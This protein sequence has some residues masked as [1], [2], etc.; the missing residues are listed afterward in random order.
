MEE[1]E[2]DVELTV[3]DLYGFSMRHTY[4]GISG[5]FGLIISL[6][7]LVICGIQFKQLDTTARIALLIIGCLFTVV[8]P[9]MLYTKAKTQ[10]KQN[11]NINS[12]L[13]Y[14]LAEEGIEVSQG[15]QTVFVK[16]FDVRRKVE[17]GKAIYLYMSPVRA[18]IFPANQCGMRFKQICKFIECQMEK[19]KEH[20]FEEENREDSRE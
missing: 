15:E 4:T 14:K 18:F 10:V 6:G 13:H 8:Q 17:T 11:E 5:I 16:W 9:I 1:I 2:F 7:S 3:K 12:A 20:D 19:H